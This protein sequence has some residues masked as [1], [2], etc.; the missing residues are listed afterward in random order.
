MSSSKE[1]LG[2]EDVIVYTIGI[3]KQTAGNLR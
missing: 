3:Y 2:Y 1:K